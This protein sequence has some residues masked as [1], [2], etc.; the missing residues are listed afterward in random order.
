MQLL[1]N[2]DRSRCWD[3]QH[4]RRKSSVYLTRHA[5]MSRVRKLL[6]ALG[7]FRSNGKRKTKKKKSGEVRRG[8]NFF[9]EL[10][11]GARERANKRQ[12]KIIPP[13]VA[14]RIFHPLILEGE[15][16]L[17]LK[18]FRDINLVGTREELPCI[19]DD[20]EK[21]VEANYIERCIHLYTRARVLYIYIHTRI[22]TQIHT[23]CIH[24]TKVKRNSLCFRAA[25]LIGGACSRARVTFF[26]EHENST[27]VTLVH[28]GPRARASRIRVSGGGG[29]FVEEIVDKGSSYFSNVSVNIQ[30]LYPTPSTDSLTL[31]LS[32]GS[33]VCAVF[34]GHIAYN[35]IHTL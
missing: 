1:R 10:E 34:R 17:K 22:Q 26:R 8:K 20:E 32:S 27:R 2:N 31:S 12:G 5:G 35:Y 11:G 13:K 25:L 19:T 6:S 29:G 9:S 7:V 15:L 3:R 18:C 30:R 14:W 24:W 4:V 23:T 33:D 28:V 16:P 21:D